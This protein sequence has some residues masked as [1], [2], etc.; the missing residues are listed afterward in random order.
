MKKSKKSTRIIVVVV[1]IIII[2][3]LVIFDKA[4]GQ[5]SLADTNRFKEQRLAFG[6]SAGPTLNEDRFGRNIEG[7]I[8][9]RWRW[10]GAELGVGTSSRAVEFGDLNADYLKIGPTF[11]GEYGIVDLTTNIYV[12]W[13][14]GSKPTETRRGKINQCYA[15]LAQRVM[16]NGQLNPSMSIGFFISVG[17]EFKPN[18]DYLGNA[19]MGIAMRLIPKKKVIHGPKGP[20]AA[21]F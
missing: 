9:W 4:F 8:S 2:A 12:G 11:T 10:I 16:I 21:M 3:L 1:I 20:F 14:N 19:Q 18:H 6:G 5:S 17:I 13:E 15:G 7:F